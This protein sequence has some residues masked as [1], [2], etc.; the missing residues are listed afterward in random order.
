MSTNSDI[1]HNRSLHLSPAVLPSSELEFITLPSASIVAG[2][3]REI[4]MNLYSNHS[5]FFLFLFCFLFFYATAICLNLHA[6]HCSLL[7]HVL[8]SIGR[9]HSRVQLL[10]LL[11]RSRFFER[12]WC[13]SSRHTCASGAPSTFHRPGSL[14]DPAL[15]LT[16]HLNSDALRC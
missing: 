7:G 6:G 12:R 2:L 13:W 15:Y 9:G 10:Q 3:F 16:A 11:W 14:S 8:G 4:F 1:H 5:V